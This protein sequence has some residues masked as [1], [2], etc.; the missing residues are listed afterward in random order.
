MIDTI[1]KII[2]VLGIYALGLYSG[3]F[4][5]ALIVSNRDREDYEEDEWKNFSQNGSKQENK[6]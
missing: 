2:G 3:L 1:F 6:D 5:A 4:V